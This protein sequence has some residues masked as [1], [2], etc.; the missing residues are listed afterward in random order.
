MSERSEEI[1]MQC[2]YGKCDVYVCVWKEIERARARKHRG[3]RLLY[4]T[5][6]HFRHSAVTRFSRPSPRIIESR[7]PAIV[8]VC[9]YFT[10]D[11]IP[12]I[13]PEARENLW[14]SKAYDSVWKIIIYCQKHDHIGR[15]NIGFYCLSMHTFHDFVCS[16]SR[17]C[18][19]STPAWVMLYGRVPPV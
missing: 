7:S 3:S 17:S 8:T 10:D 9:T 14:C 13:P 18:P 16:R 2:V 6:F 12:S 5:R 4:S 11:R 19:E 1:T 15:A